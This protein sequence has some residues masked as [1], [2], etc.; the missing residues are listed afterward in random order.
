MHFGASLRLLRQEAGLS[1][2]DLSGAVGVSPAYLSR[3]EHGHDAPPTPDRLRGI[4]AALDVA[5]E[6]LFDLTGAP[7]G[8]ASA[9][10]DLAA[11]ALLAEIRRRRLGPA[12]I[13]RVLDFVEQQFPCSPGPSGVA[14]LLTSDRVLLGVRVSTLEDAVDLCALRLAPTSPE[15]LA[16]DLR[17]REALHASAVGGGLLLPHASAGTP[18]ACLALLTVP[19]AADTPDGVPIQAVLALAGLGQGPR[20]L[21]ALG[22][23]ARLASVVASLCAVGSAAEALELVRLFE[24]G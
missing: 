6:L 7:P 14:A 2:R 10:G 3:V 23:A 13:A 5:P 15:R 11:S 1:L 16:T 20:A 18:A 19:V 24:R 4:A 21:S 22:R 9:D 17:R 12:Q 8:H